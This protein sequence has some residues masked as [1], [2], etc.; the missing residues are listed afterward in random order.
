MSEGRLDDIGKLQLVPLSTKR[1][2]RQTES[3]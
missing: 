1:F 2:V 3:S